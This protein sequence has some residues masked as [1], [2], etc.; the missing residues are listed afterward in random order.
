MRTL[1]KSL[2]CLIN[3]FVYIDSSPFFS[4]VCLS[5]AFDAPLP[6]DVHRLVWIE[7][8][9]VAM[10]FEQTFNGLKSMNSARKISEKPS[11]IWLKIYSTSKIVHEADSCRLL[12]LLQSFSWKCNQRKN[13]CRVNRCG[14]NHYYASWFLCNSFCTFTQS[15]CLHFFLKCFDFFWMIYFDSFVLQ[16]ISIHSIRFLRRFHWVHSFQLDTP[17]FYLLLS[18]LYEVNYFYIF[19]F[20][21]T[22]LANLEGFFKLMMEKDARKCCALSFLN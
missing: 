5:I 10:P 21:M 11:I 22:F 4:L 13:E 16:L 19:S 12:F 15:I 9:P 6:S 1:R 7:E 17:S 14:T 20:S 2:D 18:I 8:K 3:W